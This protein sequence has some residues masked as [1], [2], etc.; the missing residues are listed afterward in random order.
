[1]TPLY[2]FFIL[3]LAVMVGCGTLSIIS[4]IRQRKISMEIYHLKCVFQDFLTMQERSMGEI[5]GEMRSL[6]LYPTEVKKNVES[7]I[8]WSNSD[9]QAPSRGSTLNDSIE[10]QES[11]EISL[12]KKQ[13][14]DMAN[15]GWNVEEISR[16]SQLPPGQVDVILNMRAITESGDKT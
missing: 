7:T 9:M 16:Q 4:I 8:P 11:Q 1:M 14:W 3:A 6:G 2:T 15:L 12:K 5:R 13:V 10:Y